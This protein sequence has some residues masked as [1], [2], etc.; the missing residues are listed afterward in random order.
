MGKLRSFRTHIKE[1]CNACPGAPQHNKD[2]IIMANSN[3]IRSNDNIDAGCVGNNDG[4]I[5]TDKEDTKQQQ[6][7]MKTDEINLTVD[8]EDEQESERR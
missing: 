7:T 5:S 2:Q 3:S 6:S 8:Q 1:F 4:S